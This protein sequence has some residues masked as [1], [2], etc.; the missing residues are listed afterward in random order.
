M[1]VPTSEVGYTTATTGS[2][3]HEVQD[4]RGGTGFKKVYM[5]DGSCYK[6]GRWKDLKQRFLMINF[7]EQDH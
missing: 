7:I 6:N 2:R 1:G 4:G 5:I 3:D